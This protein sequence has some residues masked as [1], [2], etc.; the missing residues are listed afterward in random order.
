MP[1]G[2]IT[3]TIP[4]DDAVPTFTNM[5]IENE[6]ERERERARER[7]QENY[8]EREKKRRLKEWAREKKMNLIR[9]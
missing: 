5:A 3:Q 6:R 8:R 1:L 7:Q 9:G 2:Y 4:T